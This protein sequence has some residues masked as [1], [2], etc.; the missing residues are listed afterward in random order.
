MDEDEVIRRFG[1]PPRPADLPELRRQLVESARLESA[2]NGDTLVM[3][4]LSVLLFAAGHP[5]DS[6]LIWRAKN[7]SFDASCSLDVQLLCGAGFDATL[8]FLHAVDSDEARAA[9]AYIRKCDATGDFKTLSEMASVYR[10]Y[11]GV[12]R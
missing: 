4:A 3:K 1:F 7:A 6:L 12:E 11:Y 2:G 5:E 10:R 9:L 8:R